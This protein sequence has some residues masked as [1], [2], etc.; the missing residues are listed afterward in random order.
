[1]YCCWAIGHQSYSFSAFW[2]I[3]PV[4]KTSTKYLFGARHTPQG[5]HRRIF[6]VIPCG[7][8]TSNG[9]PSATGGFLR[10]LVRELGIPK[11]AK[12]LPMGN[13]SKYTKCHYTADPI[14][15]KDGSKCAIPTKEVS[16]GGVN[17]VTLNSTLRQLWRH[18]GFPFI[19]IY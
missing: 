9:V 15:S 19:Y 10:L 17:N 3:F 5:L 2:P 8:R 6:L 4:Y 14:W 12:I 13:A 7:S 18:C 11:F 16:L 1:M